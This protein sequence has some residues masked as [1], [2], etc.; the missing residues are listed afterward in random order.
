MNAPSIDIKDMLEAFGESSGLDVEFADNLF[1]GHEPAEPDNCVTIFDTAGFPPYMGLTTV[2]YEYPAVYI[3]VRDLSYV[4]GWN[5][6]NAIKDALHGRANET[7]NGTLYTMIKC[8][9]GPALLD[10][11][12]HNRARFVINFNL[13]RR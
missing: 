10:Y 2:G 8:S 5:M 1:I 12:D 13:Q 3:R 7:W 11:D 6:A 9:S 4:N